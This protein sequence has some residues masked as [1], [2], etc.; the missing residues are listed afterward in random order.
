MEQLSMRLRQSLEVLVI[1]LEE[2]NQSCAHPV[3]VKRLHTICLCWS[4]SK[5]KGWGLLV[6]KNDGVY[7][8]QYLQSFLCFNCIH[9]FLYPPHIYVHIFLHNISKIKTN[10][11]LN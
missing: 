10:I 4:F 2:I 1:W 8:V 7:H 6:K 11:K 3:K 5:A 9:I